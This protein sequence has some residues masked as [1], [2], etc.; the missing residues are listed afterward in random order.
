RCPVPRRCIRS[1]PESAQ[2]RTVSVLTP[3]RSATCPTRYVVTDPDSNDPRLGET[4]RSDSFVPQTRGTAAISL[5][6]ASDTWQ[7]SVAGPHLSNSEL[8]ADPHLNNSEFGAVCAPEFRDARSY[9]AV[10][11]S[12]QGWCG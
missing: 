1:R 3:S 7:A 4:S 6:S 9:G 11:R 8:I 5:A 10:M 2:R 12:D